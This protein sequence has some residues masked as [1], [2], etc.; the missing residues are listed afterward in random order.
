MH[1]PILNDT[2]FFY[3]S[4]IV[5]E[6]HFCALQFNFFVQLEDDCCCS[7]SVSVTYGVQSKIC[8]LFVYIVHIDF[9]TFL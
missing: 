4:Y 3:G 6:I 5:Q 2:G 9:L 1:S 8:I 7:L